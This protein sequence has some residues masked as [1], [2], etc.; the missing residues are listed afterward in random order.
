MARDALLGPDKQ[1]NAAGG[2]GLCQKRGHA[3]MNRAL[4]LFGGDRVSTLGLS[5]FDPEGLT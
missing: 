2:K 4:I 5:R 3:L 1:R